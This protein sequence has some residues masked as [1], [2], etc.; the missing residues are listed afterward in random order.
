LLIYRALGDA[1][2]RRHNRRRGVWQRRFWEHAIRDEGDL[3]R[4]LDYIHHNPVKHG[5]VQ[6]ASD[7]PWSS[8]HRFVREGKY[9]ADWGCAL[10]DF[11]DLAD[12]VGE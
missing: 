3:A 12:T 10:M 2:S 8:F 9:S 7:W 1:E 6:R 5:L 4:H 11:D